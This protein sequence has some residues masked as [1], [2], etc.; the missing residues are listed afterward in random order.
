MLAINST[1]VVCGGA[2]LAGVTSAALV[3]GGVVPSTASVLVHG[4]GWLT[5][6]GALTA[7]YERG[8]RRHIPPPPLSLVPCYPTPGG[9]SLSAWRYETP[10]WGGLLPLALMGASAAWGV[11]KI[12]QHMYQAGCRAW[13]VDE[14]RV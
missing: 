12:W 13:V 9:P 3:R 11:Y 5:L 8:G 10:G 1:L 7:W 2:A 4:F 6:S 14:A